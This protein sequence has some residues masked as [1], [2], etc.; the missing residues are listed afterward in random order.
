MIKFKVGD[1]VM[2]NKQITDLLGGS[3]LPEFVKIG[4]TGE[5]ISVDMNYSAGSFARVAFNNDKY[6]NW[7]ILFSDLELSS[8]SIKYQ[9]HPLTGIF[10]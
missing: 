3:K 5:V 2:V 4:V 6:Q 1:K 7:G 8:K 9:N 10:V